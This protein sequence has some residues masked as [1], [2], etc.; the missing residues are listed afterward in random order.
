MTT[1]TNKTVMARG[2]KKSVLA[3]VVFLLY[4]VL[5]IS[6]GYS[7]N[8]EQWAADWTV[9]RV[10]GFKKPLRQLPGGEREANK[11]ESAPVDSRLRPGP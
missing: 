9:D 5:K 6:A 4:C 11:R 7:S 8:E 10:T 1:T 2:H 3:V